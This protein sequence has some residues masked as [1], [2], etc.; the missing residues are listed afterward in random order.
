MLKLDPSNY[1]IH[2]DQNK[3]LIKKSLAELGAG[4]SILFDK[5]N[6]I[7]AGNGVYE[8][9]QNLGLPVRIIESDGTELIAIKR[10]DLSTEDSRRKALALADNYTTDTSIFDMEAIVEDFS[11]EELDL[12]EFSIDD[13]GEVSVGGE[14]ENEP[15]TKKVSSPIYAPTGDKPV[16]DE[17]FDA[18]KY[19]KFVSDINSS[20]IP[21]GEKEFLKLA[22]TRHIVFDYSKIAE[23]YAHSDKETQELMENSALVIIDFNKAIELGYVKL[24]QDI[25]DQYKEDCDDEE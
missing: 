19:E 18:S 7:I 12:W 2:T 16:V 24:K 5:E 6:C 21:A 20:K 10:T 14:S 22:A 4:R 11:A 8:V 23:Y 3:R 1:R 17:L 13:I 9:A 25:A 15:Y